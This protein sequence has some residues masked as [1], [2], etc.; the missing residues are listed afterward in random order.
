M[1]PRQLLMD[2]AIREASEGGWSGT[3]KAHMGVHMYMPEKWKAEGGWEDEE[4]KKLLDD[5][6]REI[7]AENER[8]RKHSKLHAASLSE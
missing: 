5:M 2:K 3:V 1:T 8:R 6:E 7:R 4:K